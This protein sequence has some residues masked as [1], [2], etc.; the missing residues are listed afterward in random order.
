MAL[1]KLVAI[2][3]LC[4]YLASA[5]GVH[6]FFRMP[7]LARHYDTH[8]H[9]GREVSLLDFFFAHYV[10][11][12]VHEHGADAHNELPF[13]SHPETNCGFSFIAVMPVIP[14]FPRCLPHSADKRNGAE[15]PFLL[16]AGPL[17]SV[18]QPPKRC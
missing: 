8:K 15:V 3:L 11:G 16:S 18:W 1:N 17:S 7:L 5:P 6:E 13:K 10:T 2:S 9:E 12:T 4:V 14:C